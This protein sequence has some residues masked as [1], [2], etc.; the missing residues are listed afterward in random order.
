VEIGLTDWLTA[1]VEYLYVNLGTVSCNSTASCGFETSGAS[2]GASAVDSVKFSE[3]IVR[4]GV[5]FKFTP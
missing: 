2:A 4:A 5:N 1:K 3:S